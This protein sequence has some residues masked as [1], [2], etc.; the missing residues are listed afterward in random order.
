[1]RKRYAVSVCPN[2]TP[3][4]DERK[5]PMSQ[6][7][8]ADARTLN[9]I[10]HQV[11]DVTRALDATTTVYPPSLEAAQVKHEVSV[12]LSELHIHDLLPVN[13]RIE[14]PKEKKTLYCQVLR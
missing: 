5:E 8:Q 7:N 11:R 9:R 4:P 14:T 1:M 2:T 13:V 3:S 12:L 10:K 6:Y